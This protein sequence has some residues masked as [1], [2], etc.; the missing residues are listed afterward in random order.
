MPNTDVAIR[1]DESRVALEIRTPVP[2]LVLALPESAQKKPDALLSDS[3][4]IVEAYFKDHLK[5]LSSGGA[6]QTY[7]I[8]S[9]TISNTNDEFVGDYQ[10]LLLTIEVPVQNGFNPRFSAR[11]RRRYSS[12]PEPFRAR[13]NHAGF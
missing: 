12:S 11:I 10:E 8:T 4:G 7:N 2:E 5:I 6:A 13:K 9:L 3:R 1:L